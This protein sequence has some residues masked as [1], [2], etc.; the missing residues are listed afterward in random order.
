M[1]ASPAL[2]EASRGRT[3]FTGGLSPLQIAPVCLYVPACAAACAV[4]A[5]GSSL[6]APSP[7]LLLVCFLFSLSL[8][9]RKLVG[10]NK[11]TLQNTASRGRDY[12]HI[13]DNARY[14]AY[15]QLCASSYTTISN[16]YHDAAV[17]ARQPDCM[18]VRLVT[19]LI[20]PT[21]MLPSVWTTTSR[22]KD[23]CKPL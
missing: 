12:I 18:H 9:R 5:C 7:A 11:R 1:L 6:A 22:D 2:G 17:E 14:S 13:A 20:E 10:L 16:L 3:A 21:L 15:L 8:L 4:R 19:R 23:I